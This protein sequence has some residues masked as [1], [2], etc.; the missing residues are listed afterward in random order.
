MKPLSLKQIA[1]WTGGKLDP[2][3]N[4]VLVRGVNTDSRE[5]RP[6]QLF[7]PLAGTRVDGHNFIG[8]AI[9]AGAAGVLTAKEPKRDIPA[10]RVRDT[11][12]AF[13]LMAAAYR[14]SLPVKV[15]AITGSVGKTT[16]KEMLAAILR[17]RFRTTWTEGNHNNNLG[18]P[19]SIMDIEPST[20]LSV[21]EMGMNHFGEIS[22]LTRIARP[23][24]AI[25]TNIG[26]M[27]IE[28]LGSRAG[29]LKAKLE[30]LEGMGEDG[31]VVM[32]G[33]EP[34]LWDLRGKLD[35]KCWYFG[36]SNEECDVRASDIVTEDDGVRFTLKGL[37][38]T[39]DISV[40]GCGQH[41]VYNALAAAAA[42]LLSGAEPEDVSGGLANFVNTGMRQ[43]IFEQCGYTII[44][45]CY[46][47][48]PESM[49]AALEVLASHS[50]R[51]RRVAVLGDMMELGCVSSA[52]HYR[53]GRMAARRKIDLIFAYGANAA[54]VVA[55]AVT[56]GTPYQNAVC[57]D[58]QDQLI[59]ELRTRV[60]PGDVLLFKGS[61][62]MKME[63]VLKQFLA[64]YDD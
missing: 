39:L 16:T 45:D 50:C 32:N 26:T 38:K 14:A 24:M 8:R 12:E 28:Y 5:I 22:Y 53:I 49:A 25:F 34:L 29:I 31:V 35:K 41:T 52:E 10:I 54:R 63:R 51:G 44:D 36:V 43:R 27:H 2:I 59:H 1:A 20:E 17:R 33:D 23:N 57:Y 61:R 60:Q 56:G 46:N 19:M 18:L 30:V 4:D 11:L 47:A 62:G 3:Y 37:G 13:G 6:G 64:D 55:G 48:G 9:D 40:P 42:A 58:D 21:L 7:I 15:I